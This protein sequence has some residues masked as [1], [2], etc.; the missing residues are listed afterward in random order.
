MRPIV[1]QSLRPQATVEIWTG[2]GRRFSAADTAADLVTMQIHRSTDGSP[3][4][5]ALTLTARQYRD[6]SWAERVR[7]MDYVEIRASNGATQPD[8][9]LPIRMRG[10][11]TNAMQAFSIGAQGGPTR[12]VTLNGQ[13]YTKIFGMNQ[14]KYVWQTDPMAAMEQAWGL[15]LR[16][17]IPPDVSTVRQMAE[18][19]SSGLMRPF[20]AA[21]RQATGI[22]APAYRM[23]VTIPDRFGI[24]FVVVEPYTGSFWDL[25]RYFQSAPLGECFIWDAPDAPVVTYRIAPFKD[26][27]GNVVSPAVSPVLGPTDARFALAEG[28]D[29]GY[30]DN[31]VYN[32]FFVWSDLAPM[33]GFTQYA[34]VVKGKN[35]LVER[36]SLL[37]FGFRPLL[38]DAP[39]VTPFTTGA[40]KRAQPPQ[41]AANE[42]AYY[43]ER[44][45][46]HNETLASGSLQAHGSEEFIP[47]R[48]VRIADEGLTAYL[49]TVDEQFDFLGAGNP[50]WTAT[51]G[52]VRG[53]A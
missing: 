11:V 39:L 48:Y 45:Q 10:F 35:P 37:R 26:A 42:F 20:L 30:S 17:H 2:G 38:V 47:G 34:Y 8:G 3:G 14:V 18:A 49:Q 32:Y 33:V 22:P 53:Q 12:S 31:E 21:F 7:P 52:L 43:L 29:L 5:F 44:T 25:F 4:T 50:Q 6:G 28:Q 24:P 27:A 36:A 46:G 19:V 13:D 1:V 41:E 40:N 16:Y 9:R 15:T 23:D 51:L